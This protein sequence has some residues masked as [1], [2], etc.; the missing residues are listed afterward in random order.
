M[1]L[2]GVPE[3][4]GLFYHRMELQILGPQVIFTACFS[5]LDALRRTTIKP[6]HRVMTAE[7]VMALHAGAEYRVN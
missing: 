7:T 2:V 6:L 1:R 3:T 5:V 4:E